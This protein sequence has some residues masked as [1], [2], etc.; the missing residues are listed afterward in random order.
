[1]AVKLQ[2]ACF[3]RLGPPGWQVLHEVAALAREHEL[4]AIADGKRGDI[5][6]SATAYA[7]ALISGAPS[8]YG[9]LPGLRADVIT[10]NPLL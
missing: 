10:A 2:L 1:M 6:V 8:P 5:A 4:L 7:Q 9:D 3:E